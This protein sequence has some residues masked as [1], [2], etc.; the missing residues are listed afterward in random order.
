MGKKQSRVEHTSESWQFRDVS[1]Q[2][3][4]ECPNKGCSLEPS[5]GRGWL[6]SS[7]HICF[8]EGRGG[9]YRVR[10]DTSGSR[11]ATAGDGQ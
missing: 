7:A 6:G 2:A 8:R 9:K 4:E 11:G 5:T 3:S 1:S 10:I